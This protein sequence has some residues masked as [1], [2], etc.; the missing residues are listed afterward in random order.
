MRAKSLLGKKDVAFTTRGNI[1]LK[2]NLTTERRYDKNGKLVTRH[3]KARVITD[4]SFKQPTLQSFSS[5][6]SGSGIEGAKL[7]ERALQSEL[8][9]VRPVVA[10]FMQRNS[11]M[12]TLN[13]DSL[14]T[15]ASFVV[16]DETAL[17]MGL[18]QHCIQ[19][20]SF[21]PFDDIA[22]Y[23]EDTHGFI[24]GEHDN[25]FEVASYLYGLSHEEH[26]NNKD[27]GVARSYAEA[28]ALEREQMRA[29]IESAVILRKKDTGFTYTQIDADEYKRAKLRIDE[30]DRSASTFA[31]IRIRD[32]ELFKYLYEN[33]DKK[34]LVMG[35]L[36]RHQFD[37]RKDAF[38]SFGMRSLIEAAANT[39]P[40]LT[41]GL[42]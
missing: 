42:L 4:F 16:L 36:D 1:D 28:S 13:R 7:I 19:D 12:K 34:H 8:G 31:S 33:P 41:D 38:N 23:M 2:K 18:I 17:P 32:D 27:I 35:I 25:M 15:I 22:A 21:K 24:A 20:K 26:A 40:T 3:V 6:K 9:R 11:I 10:G 14:N 29:V 30:Y 37:P 5:S 39:A